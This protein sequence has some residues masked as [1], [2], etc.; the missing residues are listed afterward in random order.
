MTA[1][2][3]ERLLSRPSPPLT[4]SRSP[5]FAAIAVSGPGGPVCRGRQG[6][7][8]EACSVYILLDIV[9]VQSAALSP[10]NFPCD[11]RLSRG[12]RY[13]TNAGSAWRFNRFLNEI[14]TD[15]S[16]AASVPS[17]LPFRS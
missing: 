8:K 13:A 17:R 5:L 7:R 4:N 9:T 14:G 1:P 12:A 10:V 11:A 16:P 2:R 6:R 3:R 15:P